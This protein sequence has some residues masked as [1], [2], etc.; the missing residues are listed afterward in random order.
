MEVKRYLAK[1]QK[2]KEDDMK[3]KIIAHRGFSIL[4]FPMSS[5]IKFHDQRQSYF[6]IC[7]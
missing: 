5:S 4:I 7:I 1:H 6:F 3:L 2:R